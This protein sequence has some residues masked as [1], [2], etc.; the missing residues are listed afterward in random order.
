MKMLIV[1]LLEMTLT[2]LLMMKLL[3]SLTGVKKRV[4]WVVSCDSDNIVTTSLAVIVTNIS[5]NLHGTRMWHCMTHIIDIVLDCI[6]SNSED[7]RDW[8]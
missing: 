1:S 3:L 6:V 4:W 7:A 2:E 5:Y 8:E